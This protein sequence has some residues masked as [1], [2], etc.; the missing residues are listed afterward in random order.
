MGCACNERTERK[1]VERQIYLYTVLL[2]DVK[3]GCGLRAKSFIG[4]VWL[5]FGW[6]GSGKRTYT[7]HTHT[8]TERQRLARVK[9]GKDEPLSSR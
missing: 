1:T 6:F 5:R 4:V 7:V 3:N 8:H 9:E 2:S